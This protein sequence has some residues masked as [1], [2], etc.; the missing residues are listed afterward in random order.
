[1]PIEILVPADLKDDAIVSDFRSQLLEI[2]AARNN[3]AELTLETKANQ[4]GFYEAI[5]AALPDKVARRI[6]WKSNIAGGDIKV[7]DIIALSWIPLSRIPDLPGK[8]PPPQNL[9]RNKSECVK[10]FD[11]LM[12]NGND[13]RA[14][15][16]RS[17]L[18]P[19]EPRRPQRHQ[20]AGRPA[21]TLRQDLQGFP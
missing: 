10:L 4:K 3:N 6:E 14:Q 20:A 21:R 8:K 9:Y 2:C 17:D 5:K 15:R 18:H 7:R 16:R 1:M 13:L 12:S 11:E 19:Q